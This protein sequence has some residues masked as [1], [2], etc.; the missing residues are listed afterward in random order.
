MLA[1]VLQIGQHKRVELAGG[2]KAILYCGDEVLLAYGGRAADQFEAE[3]PEDLGGCQLVA[4]GGLAARVTTQHAKM[5]DATELR[6]I[7]LVAGA[8]GRI[9]NVRDGALA[10]PPI[11]ARRP[12]TIVVVGTSMNSGKTPP[13]RWDRAR[14]HP[15]AVAL[16]PPAPAGRLGR[17]RIRPRCVRSGHGVPDRGRVLQPAG[18]AAGTQMIILLAL[19]L[20][21]L[22]AAGAAF[23]GLE[24]WLAEKLG[25]SYAQAVRM[26][27]FGQVS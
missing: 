15:E 24:R 18:A 6:P 21:V 17:R 4:G 25:Q 1:E 10:R 7:G 11:A 23:T 8:D 3:V 13:T 19:G 20:G 12:T 9:R 27:L 14:P 2:R 22:G 5:K 16:G 26:K